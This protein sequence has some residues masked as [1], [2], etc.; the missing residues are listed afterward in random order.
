MRTALCAA[1]ELSSPQQLPPELAPPAEGKGAGG[2]FGGFGGG[3]SQP[4]LA[5]LHA[6]GYCLYRVA[7][8]AAAMRAAHARG[9]Q[10]SL[11]LASFEVV[12]SCWSQLGSLL[13][14]GEAYGPPRASLTPPLTPAAAS[15]VCPDVAHC[16]C[17]LELASTTAVVQERLVD[18][19]FCN[20]QEAA[21]LCQVGSSS[22]RSSSFSRP[23]QQGCS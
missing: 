1:L 20:E 21:A 19:I 4:R 11:D 10:V 9:A 8:A 3:G 18:V 17:G 22:C 15:L 13:Q 23:F 12:A 5:L 14:V 7:V 6:E 16:C 2:G